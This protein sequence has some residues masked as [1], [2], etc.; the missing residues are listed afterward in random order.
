MTERQ[1]KTSGAEAGGATAVLEAPRPAAPH[2]ATTPVLSWEDYFR[3]ASPAQQKELL[4]L[5]RRQG[6]LYAH[7]LPPSGNGHA[8]GHPD[9]T[10]RW[11]TLN[12]LLVNQ[13]A[14]LQPA[15]ETAFEPFDT[16]LDVHQ[17]QAVGR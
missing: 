14:D 9:Q 10:A 8:G 15:A 16:A 3:H 7:Q 13:R 1:R 6:L 5:A 4:A 11:N 2:P 12:H 17:R